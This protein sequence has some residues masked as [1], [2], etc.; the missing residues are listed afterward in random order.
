[1]PSVGFALEA[2]VEGHVVDPG[3][4]V[5]DLVDGHVDV[6]GKLLRRP[7]DAVAEADGLDGRRAEHRPAVHRHR[8]D[9][10]EEGDVGIADG[11]HIAAHIQHHGDGAQ[12]AHDAADAERVGDGLAQAVFLGDFEVG[13]GA[14]LVPADLEHADG[15][16]RAVEGCAPVEGGFDGGVGVQRFRDFVRDD[17]GRAQAFRVDVVQADGGVAEFGEAEDVADKVLREDG[18][19]GTEEDDFGHCLSSRWFDYARHFTTGVF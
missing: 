1:M 19:S 9:V 10:V 3:A 11:F 17:L 12:R 5:V 7:L 14:R 16:V 6:A 8:V 13:D 2:Q 18:A 15:V 4:D